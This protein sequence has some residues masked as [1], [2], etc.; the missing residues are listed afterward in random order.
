[1]NA[2]KY[3]VR[4]ARDAMFNPTWVVFTESIKNGSTWYDVVDAFETK[5]EAIIHARY[6]E[7][8]K[9]DEELAFLNDGPEGWEV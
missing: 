6:M 4:P 3:I 5:E 2:V 7:M 8:F 1:M 9:E